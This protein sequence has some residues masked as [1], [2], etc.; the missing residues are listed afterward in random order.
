MI[1][2]QHV[3]KSYNNAR[4]FVVHDLSLEVNEGELL[5][6]LG[7]SG[8]GKSTTLKMINRLVEPTSGRIK[9]AGQDTALI[10]SVQLRRSI[11][12]AFQHV[13]LFPHLTVARNVG[14]PLH[15]LNW[16]PADIAARV[17]ELLL[18]M[19][20][21]PEDYCDRMPDQLSGGQKQRVGL[22]R[23]LAARPKIMLMD[24]P[25][26]SVDPLTRDHLRREFAKLQ[27]ELRLTVVLVTHDMMEALLIGNRIAIMEGGRIVTLGTPQALLHDPGHPYAAALLEAPR[28]QAD[29]LEEM[30]SARQ[31]R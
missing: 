17:D 8:C 4:S 21:P 31:H 28:R 9:V 14:L 23:A 18:L 7:E 26:G 29:L 27:R 12:Y 1:S 25:F 19:S 16:E 6:L 3:F 22:A 10:D 11:G 5:V 24:E 13:G 15:L 20:L 30:I 2:L